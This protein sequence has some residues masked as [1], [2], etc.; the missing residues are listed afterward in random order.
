LVKAIKDSHKFVNFREFTPL[1]YQLFAKLP[2]EPIRYQPYSVARRRPVTT[3]VATNRSSLG[4]QRQTDKEL[5]IM[6]TENE[7]KICDLLNEVVAY[8]KRNKPELP[9]I[10]LRIAGGWV[11]DKYLGHECNDL[12]VAINNMMGL[13]FCEKIGEYLRLKGLDVRNVHKIKLNPDKSKHLE[14]AATIIFGQ[15]IDFANLRSEEY[16]EE[17]RIPKTMFGTPEQDAYRRDLTIN[18][19]FYN[20]HTRQIEDYTKKGISD[21]KE[22]LIRTP[23]PAFETF[24]EDPLRVLR[25]IRF[26]SRFRFTIVEDILNAVK[27]ER[28]KEAFS[29]KISRERIAIELDKM[30]K[31]P[32]PVMSIELIYDL[33]LYEAI[34]TPPS[35]EIYEGTMGYPGDTVKIAKILEWLLSP[36]DKI[37][38]HRELL[39]RNPEDLRSL[40]LASVLIPYKD[41][42]HERSKNIIVQ[43]ILKD[44]LK[45]AKLTNSLISTINPLMELA[46]K[47]AEFPLD[48]K[49]L[50]IFIRT[51]TGPHWINS[52][53]IT[54]AYEL[55][56][57][58][59]NIKTESLYK[60]R[61]II[62]KYND[63]VDRIFD[64]GLQECFKDKH[65]LNG[66]Q[67][68]ELLNIKGGEHMKE[69]MD[70]V[71]EWQ[72]ENPGGSVEQCQEFIKSRYDEIKDS[73]NNKTNRKTSS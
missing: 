56:P 59:E 30:I 52:F 19:L 22:G 37:S 64:L 23:L 3:S 5:K 47:N 72:L 2:R 25:C 73:P 35:R 68:M 20:I 31:G 14:T 55:L 66:S 65:I 12:D 57:E 53:I 34:F 70:F 33:G 6:L 69:I 71:I 8:L 49:S 10:E 28:L 7:S 29:K 16:A 61:Q 9:S 45:D 43:Y 17:S 60:V 46:R 24:M 36:T 58:F 1:Q 15:E 54:M 21:L 50:G 44:N 67:I 40:Y 11:R 4:T 13:E 18:S 32:N 38:V 63:L 51:V 27:D 39:P 41:M 48:R 42:L 62:R 26:A